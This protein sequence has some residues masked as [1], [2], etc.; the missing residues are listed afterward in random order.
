MTIKRVV[1]LVAVLRLAR[2]WIRDA[3]KIR[4]ITRVTAVLLISGMFSMLGPPLAL[5]RLYVFF[6][7][8]A[9][10]AFCLWHGWLHVRKGEPAPVLWAFRLGALVL[11]SV[12]ITEISGYAAFAFFGSVH[13]RGPFLRPLSCG[14]CLSWSVAPWNWFLTTSRRLSSSAMHRPL[15]RD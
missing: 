3:W 8:L 7:S 10:L 11:L 2:G 12:T 6:V 13:S 4:I 15:S 1:S 9:G 5:F 14:T